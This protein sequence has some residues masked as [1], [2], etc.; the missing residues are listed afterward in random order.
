MSATPNQPSTHRAFFNADISAPAFKN[1]L[2]RNVLISRV[3]SSNNKLTLIHAPPGYGKTS[4]MKQ[5]ADKLQQPYLWLN[6]RQTDNDPMN[7]L[8]KLNTA[9]AFSQQTDSHT[10]SATNADP[11]AASISNPSI[12]LWTRSLIDLINKQPRLLI[13]LNDA[14]L[15]H[16]PEAIEAINLVLQMS[17]T[18]IQFCLTGNGAMPFSF[19]HLLIENQMLQLNQDDLCFSA[20]DIQAMFALLQNTQL[21]DDQA[22][23]LMALSEGWPAAA[24][25]MASTLQSEAAL[26]RFI[27]DANL[28]QQAFDRFFIERVFEQQSEETRQL[29]LRLS[30][31]DRFNLALCQVLSDSPE[32]CLAFWN[33]VE[34]HTFITPIDARGQW[35]RFHQLF[36]LFLRHRSQLAFTADMREQW[37]M[38][39]A[40]Y[41]HQTEAIEEAI[42]LALQAKQFTKAAHWL[43]QAFPTMVVGMGKHHTYHQWYN[44]LP[45][46]II[47]AFPRLRI[48]SIW[49]QVAKRQFLNVA[50][51]L[52]WLISH[53]S[54]YPE[55]VQQEIMRTAGLVHCCMEGLKDNAE[56]AAPLVDAWLKRWQ[57][58]A[59]YAD[60]RQR[61]YE[62]GL[63]YLIKGYCAKCLSSFQEARQAFH[64]SIEHLQAFGSFYGITL[65][66]SLLAV[67]YAKQGKHH[68]ARREAQEAYQLARQKLGEK[69]HNGF[70]LAA[71]LAAIHYEHDEIEA[72]R[73]LLK[74]TLPY[75][76]EQ[77]PSD[78]LIAAFETQAR[79]LIHDQAYEEAFGFLKDAIKW[80]ETQ[81]LPR[82]TYKLLDELIVMLIRRQRF[83]EAERYASE[84]DLILRSAADFNI[85]QRHHNIA[86]RSII[87]C[88][89]QR[90]AYA[91]AKKILEQLHARAEQKG[92]LRRQ[93]EWLKLMAI[94]YQF[95]RDNE[96]ALEAAHRLLEI[97]APQQYVRLWL[98][99][100]LCL[101]VLKL[102][103]DKPQ[104]QAL[105]SDTQA[106]YHTLCKKMQAENPTAQNLVEPL[107]AKEIEI[108]N[109]LS[110][111]LPNKVI[112][113]RML[114]SLGT[115]KWHL[116]NIYSKLAVTNRTQA[117]NKARTEG[118][119]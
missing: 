9:L 110:E 70:G 100:A 2:I 26:T 16:T 49:A 34:Q 12:P 83:S 101:P 54:A 81:S 85:N 102:L 116:H 71:L 35:F 68:E 94:N 48:G 27:A 79:L 53:K 67:T 119:L 92:Q 50:Q 15:I 111:G 38:K 14:D 103:G 73:P 65:V 21:D 105:N 99:E 40:N 78:L 66:Q 90:K 13:F 58:P 118:Y 82:L 7:L 72:A 8:H 42:A 32:Q 24:F 61:D 98:D 80:A 31:L 22:Q 46:D 88:L 114:V 39:A 19:S 69:S 106:F 17:H 52:Q 93:A 117:L 33:Y 104:L 87:Y 3:L 77:S 59:C 47:E 41:F 84:Y 5:L 96:Q 63:A 1:H 11:L 115:L 76:K 44:A 74:D 56:K 30:Q 107:T 64:Q 75:L 51:Q 20:Q 91:E 45:A 62:M 89:W 86:A 113:E 23:Q 43:E 109:A 4:F 18:G 97:S 6:I 37:L 60:A 112:A 57:T 10:P 108:I 95:S 55:A 36:A 25:Y 29:L 28:K